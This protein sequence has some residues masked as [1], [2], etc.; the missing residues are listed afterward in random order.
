MIIMEKEIRITRQR[1]QYS[2]R[3]K[4]SD[5][6]KLPESITGDWKAFKSLWEDNF[7]Q[8]ICPYKIITNEGLEVL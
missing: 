4:I 8:S 5:K 7:N 2:T 6:Y 3:K 1:I